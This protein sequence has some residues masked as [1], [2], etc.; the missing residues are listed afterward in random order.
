MKPGVRSILYAPA[1]SF[2]DFSC[3]PAGSSIRLSDHLSGFLSNLPFTQDSVSVAE[4]W[5]YDEN[6]RSCDFTLSAA[7]RVD[8]DSWRPVLRRMTGKK[9]IFV[10]T[11]ISGEQ[12]II[13]SHQYMPVFTFEDGMSGISSDGFTFQISHQSLHGPVMVSQ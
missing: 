12:Y 1:S 11:L 8:K 9:Y 7:L 4:K 2:D 3:I 10:V 5:K 13:G 6:G